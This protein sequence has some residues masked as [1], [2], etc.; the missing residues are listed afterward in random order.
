MPFDTL[1]L[2]GAGLLGGSVGLAARRR[3]VV[4]R[5][6]GTDCDDH[7]LRRALSLGILDMTCTGAAEA[8]AS[9]DLVV[10]CTPVDHIAALVLATAPHCRPGTLLMD[11][12]STKADIVKAVDGRLPASVAFVGSHPLAGSEKH[13][14]EHADA[15]LF[16]GRLVVL[17]PNGAAE[18]ALGRAAA[19]W[20][21]LGARIRLLDAAEHDRALALTSHLPHLVATALAG[22]VPPELFD[23]TATGF[24][25]T[26]RLAAGRPDVWAPIFLANRDAVLAGLDTFRAR[27]DLFRG[28]LEA[29]D[30]A[31]VVQLL[32]Q[33]QQLRDSLARPRNT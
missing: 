32:T 29:G 19:F 4:S 12:G 2:V 1:A 21:A 7:A 24:E 22:T 31:R 14:P 18:D 11:V 16:V 28:A 8:V 10:I 26:T 5:V 3:G 9:A 13:G 6:I 20:Q 23:L 33:A 30:R 25:D 27:L 15:D 17:T